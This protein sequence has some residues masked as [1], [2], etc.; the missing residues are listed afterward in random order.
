MTFLSFLSGFRSPAKGHW[1]TSRS[2][3]FEEAG[4]CS[5]QSTGLPGSV[6]SDLSTSPDASLG[7]RTAPPGVVRWNLALWHVAAAFG[8]TLPETIMEVEYMHV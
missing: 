7:G 1:E 8:P 3:H 6:A 5:K 4:S 2:G